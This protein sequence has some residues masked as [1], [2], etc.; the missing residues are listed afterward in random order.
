MR[1]SLFVERWCFHVVLLC[2]VVSVLFRCDTAFIRFCCD[3][4]F[5]QFHC[6]SPSCDFVVVS[7][8]CDFVVVSPSCDFIVISPSCDCSFEWLLFNVAPLRFVGCLFFI[9]GLLN[10]PLCV[11]RGASFF[12]GGLL[13][14]LF[15]FCGVPLFSSEV[16]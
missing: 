3:I 15:S 14:E 16:F 12:I 2:D 7:P 13:N 1:A 8:S 5:V 9:G 4:A 6:I 10:E 11:L